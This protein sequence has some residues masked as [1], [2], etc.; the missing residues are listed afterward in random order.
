MSIKGRNATKAMTIVDITATPE[1]IDTIKL[2]RSVLR[3][4]RN[5]NLFLG[6][7][8]SGIPRKNTAFA[9]VLTI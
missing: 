5:E 7:K 1:I 3:K 6:N 9:I 4:C 8:T 2:F